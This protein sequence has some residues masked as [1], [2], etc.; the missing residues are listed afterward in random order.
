MKVPWV[1]IVLGGVRFMHQRLGESRPYP[2]R[3][4]SGGMQQ[5]LE[6]SV[7]VDRLP[8]ERE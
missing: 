3:E 5:E 4:W 1:G 2:L 7:R 6:Y 8:H